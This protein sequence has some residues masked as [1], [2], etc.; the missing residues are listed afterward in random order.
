M[1]SSA[2]CIVYFVCTAFVLEFSHGDLF[3]VLG[4]RNSVFFFVNLLQF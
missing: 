4:A 3:S 1:F 2:F